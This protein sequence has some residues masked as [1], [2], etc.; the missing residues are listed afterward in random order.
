ML[1]I[2][3]L[4]V[5]VASCPAGL[6]GEITH[7]QLEPGVSRYKS[8]IYSIIKAQGGSMQSLTTRTFNDAV[9]EEL[10]L[11]ESYLPYDNT[12]HDDP[13]PMPDEND[14]EDE[15]QSKE[16]GKGMQL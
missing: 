14:D 13:A 9:T 5:F 15:G 12:D 7:C 8:A 3:D 11:R 16:D 1:S 2:N 4:P 6:L 10:H